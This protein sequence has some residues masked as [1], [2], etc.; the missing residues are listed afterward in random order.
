MGQSSAASAERIA[1]VCTILLQT[2][3]VHRHADALELKA[4]ARVD[5]LKSFQGGES[6]ACVSAQ[7]KRA[8]AK[9]TRCGEG[10]EEK[11]YNVCC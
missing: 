9:V 2:L 10:R 11:P 3:C 1:G 5:S 7:A 8:S 4:S 6:V